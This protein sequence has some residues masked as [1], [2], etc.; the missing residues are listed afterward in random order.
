MRIAAVLTAA[1]L[2]LPLGACAPALTPQQIAERD[3]AAQGGRME[4]VGRM[5]TLQC[6]IAYPD[7]GKTCRDGDDCLGDCRVPG[8]VIVEDG[9]PVA[10]Q[11][12][13]TSDRFGCYTRVEDGR[14]TAAICVD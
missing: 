4:R 11:C 2:M 13:A 3:C 8:G 7:A 10:G 14:A 12:A 5:Q 1:A 6:V 9:R